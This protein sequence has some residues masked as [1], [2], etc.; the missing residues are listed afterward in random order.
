MAVSGESI[1]GIF[2]ILMLAAAFGAGSGEPVEEPNYAPWCVD[3]IDN[4]GD[5]FTDLE[6]EHC[7][8]EW[9]YGELALNEEPIPRP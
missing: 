3:G 9:G 4:D 2:A 7:G 6:D 1:F 8:A 5:G